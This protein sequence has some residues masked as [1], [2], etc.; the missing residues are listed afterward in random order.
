[1]GHLTLA[2]KIMAKNGPSED[3]R[4]R[5]RQ[6]KKTAYKDQQR[7]EQ[8]T[9]QR[10][11]KREHQRVGGM[12]KP[13]GMAVERLRQLADEYRKQ[14]MPFSPSHPVD[15]K[16]EQEDDEDIVHLIIEAITGG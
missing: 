11:A 15:T 2:A 4:I 10:E 7:Q 8:L 9:A 14:P 16:N 5:D 1:V 3:E 13:H 12:V 6:A